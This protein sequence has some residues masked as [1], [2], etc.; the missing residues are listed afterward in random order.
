MYIYEKFGLLKKIPSIRKGY[1]IIN[2]SPLSHFIDICP[3]FS[4][5]E[6]MDIQDIYLQIWLRH[7]FNQ[8]GSSSKLILHKFVITSFTLSTEA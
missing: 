4:F 2:T 1:Q 3:F 7:Y 5:L 8:Q 6:L